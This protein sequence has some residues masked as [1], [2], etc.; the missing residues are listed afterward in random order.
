MGEE[1]LVY[2]TEKGGED[3]LVLKSVFCV[4]NGDVKET[5]KETKVLKDISHPD[6]V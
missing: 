1:F 3:M 2:E 4:N 6:I 5:I